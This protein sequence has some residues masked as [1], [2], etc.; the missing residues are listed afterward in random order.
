MMV[1]AIKVVEVEAKRVDA[2]GS[3]STMVLSDKLDVEIFS[4]NVFWDLHSYVS[5]HDE[6]W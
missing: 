4:K 2:Y 5:F 1:E 6:L 3:Y